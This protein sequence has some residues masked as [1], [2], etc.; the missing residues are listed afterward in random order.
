MHGLPS[1]Q[2]TGGGS[3]EAGGG[4]LRRSVGANGQWPSLNPNGPGYSHLR[5]AFHGVNGILTS[6]YS[7]HRVFSEGG[8]LDPETVPASITPESPG[9]GREFLD[10]VKSRALCS[11][12]VAYHY[13]VH[14]ALNLG[15]L[16][17][18]VG[19][20]IHWDAERE[21]VIDDREANRLLE[22]RYREPWRLPV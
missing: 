5:I 18:R 17:Y 20:K 22:P 11:C 2:S 13:N 16:A 14:V 1:S 8:R 19:R 4:Q 10:A 9:H 21:E 7:E 12:D 15:D 6:N 3:V